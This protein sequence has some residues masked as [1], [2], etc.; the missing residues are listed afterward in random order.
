M[1]D[2]YAFED[3]AILAIIVNKNKMLDFTIFLKYKLGLD[4]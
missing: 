3:F 1:K 2:V 4:F